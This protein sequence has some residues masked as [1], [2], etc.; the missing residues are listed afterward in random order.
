MDN[1]H[2]KY[3]TYLKYRW[4]H[5]LLDFEEHI[6]NGQELKPIKHLIKHIIKKEYNKIICP[7][8]SM[9][10]LLISLP[11][12]NKITFEKTL[13]VEIDNIR[14][15]VRFR[16]TVNKELTWSETCQFSEICDTFDYFMSSECKDWNLNSPN[17]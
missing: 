4:A 2:P 14:S 6:E 13:K 5:A 1:I 8:F 11:I 9:F 16:Y 7:G 3:K 12:D 17:T 15:I 10:R